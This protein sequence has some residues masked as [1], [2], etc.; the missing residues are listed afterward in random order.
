LYRFS[1]A[2]EDAK[3]FKRV[4]IM[5]RGLPI[6]WMLWVIACSIISAALIP[7]H[8]VWVQSI[9]VVFAGLAV[10]PAIVVGIVQFVGGLL[11]FIN[12]KRKRR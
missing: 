1:A 11:S 9:G 2:S 10:I 8:N 5:Y 12:R 3:H 6:E 7:W 4:Q